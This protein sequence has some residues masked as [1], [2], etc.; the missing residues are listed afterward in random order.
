MDLTHEEIEKYVEQISSG[1]KIVDIDDKTIIF[2]YPDQSIWMR[3]R[4]VY[5][6]EYREAIQEGLLPVEDMRKV[7]YDRQIITTEELKELSSLESKLEGQK[8]LLAKTTKV[9][10]NQ[11]RIKS[12]IHELEDKI[13]IIRY[14]EQSKLTMTAE[15]KAEESKLLYLCWSSSYDFYTDNLYWKTYEDFLKE[16]NLS[17]RQKTMSEFILF[18]SGINTSHIRAI[19]RS[20]IWRI[21]YVTSL[22]TSEPLFGVPTSNYTNDMLNLAY[23]SHY[24][25][26]IY[27]MMPEDQPSEIVIEDDEALD[28]Y[29]NDYYNE[30]QRDAAARKSKNKHSNSKLSAFDKD[31][32]II[33]KSNE[34]YEDIEYNKPRESQVVKD[35]NMIRK[36]ARG[37]RSS[38]RK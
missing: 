21:R 10:A 38:R 2:R 37:T 12:I 17:F 24:Y 1:I 36:R 32:V 6:K 35:R 22:K 30:R 11:D 4:R 3:A 13:R 27:E 8:V 19:A 18:Y 33:T 16:T 25:Q 15:T 20:N 34:L 29:L 7:I 26:N 23:W 9:K 31:E 28:A 5:D 14:K